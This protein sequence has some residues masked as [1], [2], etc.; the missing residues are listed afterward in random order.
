MHE[1]PEILFMRPSNNLDQ[2]SFHPR[3]HLPYQRYNVFPFM[4][5]TFEML[6][7][8]QLFWM[9]PGVTI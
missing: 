4:D 9:S 6:L 1:A 2:L 7:L 5:A 3:L 8:S